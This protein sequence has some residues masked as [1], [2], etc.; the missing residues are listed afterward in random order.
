MKGDDDESVVNALVLSDLSAL[1]RKLFFR[2]LSHSIRESQDLKLRR[3]GPLQ[4]P[5]LPPKI[6]LA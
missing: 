1:V 5:K 3:G 2:L 4:A 6:L